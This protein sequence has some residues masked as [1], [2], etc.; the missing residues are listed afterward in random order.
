MTTPATP[1][2]IWVESRRRLIPGTVIGSIIELI[3]APVCPS[4]V[5]QSATSSASMAW[6][7]FMPCGCLVIRSANEWPAPIYSKA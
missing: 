5:A 7:S 6:A 2:Q 4:G 1:E 3:S